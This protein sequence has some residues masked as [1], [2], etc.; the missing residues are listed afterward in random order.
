VPS[1]VH[2]LGPAQVN[3]RPSGQHG[4][5]GYYTLSLGEGLPQERRSVAWFDGQ[6]CSL[7]AS[8]GSPIYEPNTVQNGSFHEQTCAQIRNFLSFLFTFPKWGPWRNV[9][10]PPWIATGSGDGGKSG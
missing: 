1:G 2:L 9:V 3:R 5:R 8:I 7:E 4:L 10:R 6:N